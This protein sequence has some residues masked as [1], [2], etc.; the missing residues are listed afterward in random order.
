MNI[1][2]LRRRCLAGTSALALLITAAACSSSDD[3]ASVVV[4]SPAAK[5]AGLCR[6]LHGQLPEKVDG[7][8]R[9]DPGPTS[10]LTAGWGD[11]AIILRCGVERPPK[12]IDTTYAGKNSVD[13]NGVAWLLQKHDDGSYTFTTGARLA[14]VEVTLPAERAGG[15]LSPLTDFAAPIKK[16]IPK[17]IA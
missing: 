11:P 8:E 1:P 17:G 5:A 6:D 7:L 16:T 2:R 10:E 4:P 13:V 12:M 15:G 3:E 9:T 14:Y